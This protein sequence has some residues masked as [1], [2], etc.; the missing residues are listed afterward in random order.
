MLIRASFVLGAALACA[1]CSGS[2][3]LDGARSAADAARRGVDY[4][5]ARPS[6]SGLRAAGYTFAVRYFSHD[7]SK[8]L[9]AGEARALVAAGVDVVSNWE[10]TSGSALGGYDAGV[11]DASAADSEAGAA[12]S[13]AGR[14]IY[15]SID[16]DAAPGQQAALDAYMDGAASVIGRARVGAYGGYYVIQRLF[17]HGKIAWGW[18]TYA[19]SGGQ[20]EPRAQLRQ[21]QNDVT[22]AGGA[23]DIDEAEAADFGQWNAPAS[24]ALASD[25]GQA[26]LTPGQQHFFT[27]LANGDLRHS[28]WD[29]TANRVLHDTWGGGLAGRP[30]TFVW[31][32]QQHVLA[33]ASDGTLA[34]W[35][36]DPATS[37][38]QHDAWG[39]GLAG[40]PTAAV[41]DGAQHAWAV[42][43]AGNL[44]HWYWDP[45]AGRVVQN[46]WGGGVTGRPAFLQS[47]SQ[48][49]LCARGTGVTLEHWYWDARANQIAHD[50]WDS[51]VGSDPA[52]LYVNGQQHVW[53]TD[54]ANNLQHWFWDPT[55]NA[56]TH[57]TWG[58]GAT[59]RPSVFYVDGQQHVFA[60]GPAGTLEHWF[61]DPTSR[62]I[63][64]DT[65]GSG[66]TGDPTA[67]LVS[68]QQHVWALD[69]NGDA[70]HWFWRPDSGAITHDDWGQ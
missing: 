66:I 42:D 9:S 46:S 11:N 45:G 47:P 61:W 17:D 38:V 49:H 7:P 25:G 50:T 37:Q 30:V 22:I 43:G 53:A 59:G 58:A 26:Y 35:F 32:T 63:T 57:D 44:Q 34:H 29:A 13:P 23:C 55:S 51:G 60:R 68:G 39:S 24:A 67:M 8:N 33:R 19:W 62:R 52:A 12:G 4:S 54:A 1:A 69:G 28:F 64:H 65:W 21:I 6:P 36:W 15:F 14:P 16:F 20:W 56:I 5:Y 48:Q 70:Q 27:R 31:Q 2:I 10:S 18:Q 41:V 40:D 3:D